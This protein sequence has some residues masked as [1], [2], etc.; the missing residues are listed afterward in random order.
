MLTQLIDHLA[1]SQQAGRA[2]IRT[3]GI[4]E[5]QQNDFPFRLLMANGLPSP[6]VSVKSPP[7]SSFLMSVPKNSPCLGAIADVLEA[8]DAAGSPVEYAVGEAGCCSP[9]F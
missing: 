6:E 4:T 8:V 1:V 2:D 9:L 7:I 3:V 5:S